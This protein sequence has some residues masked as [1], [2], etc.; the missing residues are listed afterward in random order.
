MNSDIHAG[1]DLLTDLVETNVRASTG[2]RFANYLVDLIFF[3]II[4]FVVAIIWALISP[5]SINDD[6]YTFT[7]ISFLDRIMIL[8][9][10]SLFMFAQEA[11]TKGRSLGKLITGT[12]AVNLDGSAISPTTALG[13]GFSRAVPFCVFSA[14]GNPCNPWQDKWT[15]TMV[16]DKKLS[17]II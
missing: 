17:A 7:G 9:L 12:H 1:H 15:N 14:F 4:L 11:L 6:E 13:R 8:I 3:Y 5:G 2:K 16:I 10:Y